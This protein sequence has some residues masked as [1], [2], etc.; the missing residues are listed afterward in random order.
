MKKPQPNTNPAN[1]LM[2]AVAQFPKQ[3]TES[4]NYKHS[5][6]EWREC[7]NHEDRGRQG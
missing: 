1:R 6:S 2:L 5:N 3:E 4:R 7:E